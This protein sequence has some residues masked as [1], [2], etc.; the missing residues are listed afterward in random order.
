M[1]LYFIIVLLKIS[2]KDK[3]GTGGKSLLR[4]LCIGYLMHVTLN[5]QG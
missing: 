4:R 1:L 2:S 5:R 3:V